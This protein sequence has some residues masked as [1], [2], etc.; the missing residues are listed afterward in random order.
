LPDHYNSVLESPAE[1]AFRVAFIAH[2]VFPVK[3]LRMLEPDLEK[4]SD[5]G[6]RVFF[7]KMQILLEMKTIQI[8]ATNLFSN[9]VHF[10][11]YAI[12]LDSAELEYM[13]KSGKRRHIVSKIQEAV[14]FASSNGAKII[15]LGGYTSILTNNGLSLAEPAGSRIITGNTLTASS[16]LIHLGKIL[17]QRPEFNKPNTIAVIGSTGNI[18][19]IISRMLYEQDDICGNLL[20]ISRLE[21]RDIDL[22]NDLIKGKK[23]KV[24]VRSSLNL[25]EAKNA[26]VIVICTNTNDPIIFPHHIADKKPVLISDLSVPSAVSE[27]VLRLP[28]V[29]VFPF[30]AFVNLSEDKEV[31]ISSYSPPGT[32]FCCA[33]E[34]ILLALDP[35]DEPLKGKIMPGAVQTI[36]KLASKHGFFH[37]I[38]SLGSFKAIK[39]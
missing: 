5:T 39:R 12:P 16:G 10:S 11:F 21:K 33:G 9:K 26:D 37:N 24:Q 29:N 35:C 2:F 23:S 3:E 15:S 6:L 30:S 19:S 14:D 8:I 34:A 27:E 17:R 32:V 18:G 25:S 20:L 36:T 22:M 1:N 31:V 4:A 28:N 38:E 13:H 7:K